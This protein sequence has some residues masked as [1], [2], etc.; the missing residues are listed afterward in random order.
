LIHEKDRGIIFPVV[1]RGVA[2]QLGLSVLMEL[3]LEK[4][5]LVYN[6]KKGTKTGGI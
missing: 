4:K 5:G 1:V 3:W 6:T 2:H